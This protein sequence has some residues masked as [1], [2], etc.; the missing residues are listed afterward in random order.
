MGMIA[1]IASFKFH[2]T[3]CGACCSYPGLIV[4]VTPRDIRVLAKHLKTDASALLKVLAFYQVEPDE[5]MDETTIQERMVF[6][7][8]KTHKG[9]AYLGMLKQASGQCIFLKD[10]KCTIY[11]ARPRICQ[12]FPFTYTQSGSGITTSISRFAA[13]SC[14]GIGQGEHVNPEKVKATGQSILKEIDEMISFARWW[15]SRPGDDLEQFKPAL[16]V[17]EMIK[18][19]RGAGM[20]QRK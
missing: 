6:P 11:P 14:P 12:S 3:K 5:T 13:D 1:S 18:F 4:N 8:L 2:C 17:S 7:A 20:Q 9:L 19:P 16:L 10:N 15:N